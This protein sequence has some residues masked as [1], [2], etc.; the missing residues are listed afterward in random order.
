ML[1]V[2]AM[3]A[4]A[5]RLK[6][7]SFSQYGE[8]LALA[9][10]LAPLRQGAYVDVGAY[11]PW[12]ESNTYK[13]YL[14]GWSG[15]TV[16]P[17]PDAAAAFRR[18]R[19]RDV[20]AV[21]GIAETPGELQYYRFR[22]PKMNTFSADRAEAITESAPLPPALIP[23]RRLQDVIDEM[24]PGRSVDLLCIDCE[25][26][27][28]AALKTLDFGRTRPTAVIVEDYEALQ[29][30]IRAEGGTEIGDFMRATDYAPVGQ[31]MFSTLYVDRRALAAR[32]ADAFDF[33]R[34]QIGC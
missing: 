18:L 13:L 1:S 14:R 24:L 12:R 8:D 22:D 3:S 11:H 32:T 9:T 4:I 30:M 7:I 17:N 29:L 15:L 19:P 2:S 6:S 28:L 26:A 31:V 10:S 34:V 23:C 21:V 16:E 25:G 27:D 33:S 5:M 20:H